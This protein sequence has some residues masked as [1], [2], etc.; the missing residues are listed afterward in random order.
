MHHVVCVTQVLV[1][2]SNKMRATT[3]PP[4][5][6]ERVIAAVRRVT[7]LVLVK[8]KAAPVVIQ[9]IADV[10]LLAA[11]TLVHNDRCWINDRCLRC[12]GLEVRLWPWP[13]NIGRT[14]CL[15]ICH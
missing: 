9:L 14:L 10:H 12:Q 13:N 8:A 15:A 11:L 7:G 5:Q 4:K 2:N 1:K 3:L 6:R